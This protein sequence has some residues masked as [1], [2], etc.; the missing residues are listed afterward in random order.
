[1]LKAINV[2]DTLPN[3]KR[4]SFQKILKNLEFVCAK[5]SRNC[6]LIEREDI[7]T[8]RGRYLD[9][10]RKY[11][12][13]NRPI[14]GATVRSIYSLMHFS[15]TSLR[16]KRNPQ[17]K[18]SGLLYYTLDR[19]TALYLVIF[20]FESKT[21]SS[22]YHD[23]MDGSTFFEWFEKIIPLLKENAIM[24]MNNSFLQFSNIQ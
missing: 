9:D 3:I 13:Q 15:K 16:V 1:M 18:V 8:W 12:A 6:A 7:I 5:K 10:I 2:D 17:E 21:Y 4:S 20:C 23:E 22:N 14:Y 19:L 24:V 11:R